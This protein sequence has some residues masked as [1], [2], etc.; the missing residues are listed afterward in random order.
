MYIM[1][2]M[3]KLLRKQVYL[4]RSQDRR[5]KRRAAQE[6]VPEAD[7]IRR[8]IDLGLE[9]MGAESMPREAARKKLIAFIDDLV[10]KGPLRGGRKWTREE[11]YDRDAK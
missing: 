9:R 6:Q 4:E 10:K 7:V 11:L 1:L 5:L 3:P 2:Y 8:A